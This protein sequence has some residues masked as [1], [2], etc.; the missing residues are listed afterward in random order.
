MDNEKANKDACFARFSPSSVRENSHAL[1]PLVDK[2]FGGGGK[3]AA[4]EKFRFDKYLRE[5]QAA[6]ADGADD[7]AAGFFF[8]VSFLRLM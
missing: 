6:G 4:G 3:T 7:E 2:F 8:A 1:E 5:D